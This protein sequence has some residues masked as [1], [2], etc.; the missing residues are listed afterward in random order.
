[1]TRKIHS[2]EGNDITVT[3]DVKR[4][5]HAAECVH[6]LPEVFD[7]DKKPWIQ[8]TNGGNN[9]I[10]EVVRRCP[11]GA[12]HYDRRDGGTPEVPESRNTLAISIDGPLYLRGDIEVRDSKGEVLLRDTRVALCR[13]GASKDKPFCDNSHQNIE[14]R[15]PGEAQFESEPSAGNGTLIITC[16]ANGPY[17]IT[18]PVEILNG[19]KSPAGQTTKGALCR[20]GG[21]ANKP[22]CD[23]THKRIGF[24]SE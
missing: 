24:S 23:G 1:M 21:S 17:L 16:A 4:C 14:F 22:F 7:P 5:I 19:T 3:Y 10:A 8:P 9:E 6:G 13:C 15:D 2:F 20:C 11:T 18:G 12:L